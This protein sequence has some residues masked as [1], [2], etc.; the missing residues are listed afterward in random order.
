MLVIN[1]AAFLNSCD[2]LCTVTLFV[3]V[4]DCGVSLQSN[5]FCR[6]CKLQKDPY[7]LPKL[8]L[9]PGG[10][11]KNNSVN[12]SQDP[13]HSSMMC[14]RWRVAFLNLQIIFK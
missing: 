4:F 5:C 1:T 3:V 13:A 12:F 10:V 8:L 14:C 6:L 9:F 11:V 7:L 2:C